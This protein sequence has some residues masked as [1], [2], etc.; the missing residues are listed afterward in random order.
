MA[1]KENLTPAEET[2]VEVNAETEVKEAKAEVVADKKAPKAEKDNKKK[3]KKEKKGGLG[4]KLKEKG[5]ELKKVN[6]PSFSQ[7]VKKTGVV[8]AVVVIFAVV[9]IVSI[10]FFKPLLKKKMMT[11]KAKTNIDALINKTVVVVEPI[12]P[13]SPGTI[14][15]EVIEWTAVTE[16]DSF[17]PGDLVEIVSVAGNTFTVKKLA[18][19]G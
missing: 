16:T 11:Q 9:A 4:K 3:V 5:S 2:A 19:K 10:I 17:E 18:K 13:N 7:V 14:K 1:K 15:T 8:L 12:A 6:W